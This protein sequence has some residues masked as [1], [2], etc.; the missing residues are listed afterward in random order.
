MTVSKH[1][2]T[3]IFLTLHVQPCS[4]AIMIQFQLIMVTSLARILLARLP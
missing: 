3:N 4:T 2:G 1:P